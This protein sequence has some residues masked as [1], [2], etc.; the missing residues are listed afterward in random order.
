MDNDKKDYINT[1]KSLNL[2]PKKVKVEG[3]QEILLEMLIETPTMS[4]II[5]EQIII[6]QTD[7]GMNDLRNEIV[8]WFLE[9]PY[10]DDDKVHAFADSLELDPDK[11]ESEI[12]A[13][14]SSLLSE[15]KSKGRDI[16]VDPSQLEMGI[17]VE[18][19]HTTMPI[20]SRKIAIDHL[21]EI[22]DYYTRLDRME[23]EAGVESPEE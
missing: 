9:N 2:R 12:Y 22:P 18:M 20:I 11:F 19:E 13:V 14:L 23:K 4:D 1:L 15:G 10:P 17:K 8:R 21:V 6:Q 3:T 7:D 16:E 5:L